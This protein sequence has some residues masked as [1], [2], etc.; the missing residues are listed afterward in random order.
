MSAWPYP[1]ALFAALGPQV[2]KRKADAGDREAQFSLGYGLL[3]EADGDGGEGELKPLGAGG[4]SPVADVGF[5]L[6]AEQFPVAHGH[7][8]MWSPDQVICV[9]LPTL[10]GAGHGAPG[11]GGGARARVRYEFAGKYTPREDGARA[12][13]GVVHQGCQG[14]VA[15]SEYNLGCYLEE[16]KG[17]AAPDYPAAAGWYRRAADAG[18]GAAAQ[19]LCT[20]YQVGRGRA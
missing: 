3:N 20:M 11:E 19:A 12:S 17:V 14:R 2:V 6:C 5:A 9:R 15:E 18:H 16:G 8:S 4:R 7:C 1:S 10:V 13:R